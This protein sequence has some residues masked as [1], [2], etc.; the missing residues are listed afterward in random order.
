MMEGFFQ[1]LVQEMLW[2]RSSSITQPAWL[3][4]RNR[5]ND[6]QLPFLNLLRTLLIPLIQGE[7]RAHLDLQLLFYLQGTT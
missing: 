7:V 4:Y 6:V 5:K 3:H 2:L 1:Y